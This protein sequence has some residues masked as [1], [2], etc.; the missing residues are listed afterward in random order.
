MLAEGCA[1]PIVVARGE[2][3]SLTWA[4]AEAR[5]ARHHY[6]RTVQAMAHVFAW[7]GANAHR[8]EAFHVQEP[9]GEIGS[10]QP[11]L[12]PMAGENCKDSASAGGASC[13]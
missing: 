9:A 5:E 12:P 11:S 10:Q 4:E 7:A 3:D 8:A 2:S 6:L 1:G 13:E